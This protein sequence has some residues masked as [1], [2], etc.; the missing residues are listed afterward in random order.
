MPIKIDVVTE[1]GSRQFTVFNDTKEQSFQFVTDS[2]PK[3]VQ[4][5]HEGW[6][7]KKIAKGKY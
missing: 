5:D 3:E 1:N 2:K 4:V 7:L 6:I